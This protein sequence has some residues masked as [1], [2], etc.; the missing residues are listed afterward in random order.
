MRANSY[1]SYYAGG[2]LTTQ[3]GKLMLAATYN[4]GNQNKRQTE[5]WD[6]TTF[7]Y[8]RTGERSQ[9]NLHQ[10][11]AANIHRSDVSMSYDVDS[12][13]LISASFNGFYYKVDQNAING[14]ARWDAADNLLY[15]YNSRTSLPGYSYYDLGGRADYQHKTR[16][17]GETLTLSY[18]LSASRRHEIRRQ[19]YS[20]MVNMPVSYSGYSRNARERFTEHTFQIDY[21]RPFGKQ[22]KVETGLKYILRDNSSS[23]LMDYDGLVADEENQ[24]SHNTQVE[25]A[26]LS[27][28]FN[29][30]KW[31][32]RAGLRYEHSYMKAEYPDGS[33]TDFHRNLNDWVP[34]AS[35]QYRITDRQSLRLSYSTSI[36]R[37]GISYLNPAVIS[38]PTTIFFGNSAL[39]SS[40]NQNISLNYMLASPKLTLNLTPFC[41]F[42]NNSITRLKHEE[43]GKDVTT[44]GNQMRK[45]SFGISAYTQWQAF[46]G[47]T[48]SLNGNIFHRYVS[49]PL[50]SL[51]NSG[52]TGSAFLSLEQKLPWEI[53][54]DASVGGTFGRPIYNVYF[55]G[56]RWYNYNF[57]LT[58]D[59]LK[60]NLSVSLNANMPF[61]TRVR[62]TTRTIQGDYTGYDM[63]WNKCRNFSIRLSWKFGK[64]KSGVKKAERSIRNDD[65]VGGMEH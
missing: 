28:L 51:S 15:R 32:A 50:P 24:F 40:R 6:E 61:T 34:S 7:S 9:D 49:I 23:S 63:S 17:K 20:E 30:E 60:G 44:Y 53:S 59:F 1:G 16:L 45:R 36:Y 57:S 38:T 2:Y 52:W 46:T 10:S 37:P 65:L 4:Y 43:D 56:N 39:G 3:A 33:S 31:S 64:L 55:W 22:H 58:R 41:S 13:N 26:Y 62:D 21:V 14:L 48:L 8:V 54:L 27:Y 42:S 12:L 11:T 5:F 19:E 18:M 29:S 35:V 47:T 25:A